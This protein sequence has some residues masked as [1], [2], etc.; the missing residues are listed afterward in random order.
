MSSILRSCDLTDD[1]R[2]LLGVN[3][4]EAHRLERDGPGRS[5]ADGEYLAEAFSTAS[6]AARFLRGTSAPSTPAA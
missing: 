3:V 4:T 5:P 1:D 6:P 2:G